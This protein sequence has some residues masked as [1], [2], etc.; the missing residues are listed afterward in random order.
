IKRHAILID[1]LDVQNLVEVEAEPVA[2][3]RW[4]VTIV[5]FD[6]PGELSLICGLLR[7]FDFSIESG[8]AFT[9]E[10][11]P[12]DSFEAE[13]MWA[14]VHHDRILARD[15][16]AKI[17]DV[18]TVVPVNGPVSAETWASYRA[19]LEKALGMMQAGR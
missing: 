8:Y 7:V 11:A 13:P 19:D 5:A 16:Y 17:I 12:L 18:F 9:Y 6:Y 2:E 3:G 4:R 10:E 1:Q 14:Q 15:R